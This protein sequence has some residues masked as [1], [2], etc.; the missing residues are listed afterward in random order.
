[1]R[2]TGTVTEAVALLE[3]KVMLPTVV[4]VARADV[5]G[6]RVNVP[7]A[8]EEAGEGVSQETL[9]EAVHGIDPVPVFWTD[10]VAAAGDVPTGLNR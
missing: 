3:L 6:V 10:K 4:P 9:L 2:V 8:D 7:G 1:M 5:D